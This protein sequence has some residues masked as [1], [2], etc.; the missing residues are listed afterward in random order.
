[1]GKKNR[2]KQNRLKNKT[3]SIRYGTIFYNGGTYVGQSVNGIRQGEGK[4][5]W[6][7]EITY[8][9]KWKDDKIHGEGTYTDPHRDGGVFTGNFV[10]NAREGEGKMIW[11]DGDVYEGQW[12][13]DVPHGKGKYTYAGGVRCGE[14]GLKGVY[15]GDIVYF[16]FLLIFIICFFAYI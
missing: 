8:Q 12:K 10:N 16:S 1:M 5:V 13:E 9:G 3:K 6:E 4:M 11:N 7:N 14:F 2:R 15:T